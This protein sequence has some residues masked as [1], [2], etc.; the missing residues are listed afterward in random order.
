M[1]QHIMS[2]FWKLCFKIF[3]IKQSM[4]S[5]LMHFVSCIFFDKFLCRLYLYLFIFTCV[6]VGVSF[7]QYSSAERL[8][9]SFFA[10]DA[11]LTPVL[12]LGAGACAGI[13][14]M[15]ATYPMDMVRGRLTVQVLCWL[16]LC[17]GKDRFVF[18][19]FCCAQVIIF[20]FKF[21]SSIL[22]RQEQDS[23]KIS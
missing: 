7:C 16:F 5:G 19:Q 9:L 20:L 22:S 23:F 2:Y 18:K 17:V 13:I 11:E 10:E 21:Y 12:R 1:L 15:S 4:M 8:I 3:F 14:A 6:V